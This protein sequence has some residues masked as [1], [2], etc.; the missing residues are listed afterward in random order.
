MPQAGYMHP[1]LSIRIKDAD[2]KMINSASQS[3]APIYP[4][5]FYVARL[6]PAYTENVLFMQMSHYELEW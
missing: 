1:E 6:S 4:E 3:R 5:H 2:I